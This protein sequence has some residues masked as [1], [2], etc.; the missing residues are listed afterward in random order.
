MCSVIA[1]CSDVQIHTFQHTENRGGQIITEDLCDEHTL[2][3]QRH[4]NEI[5]MQRT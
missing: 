2:D 4:S 1:Q 3:Y 5:E